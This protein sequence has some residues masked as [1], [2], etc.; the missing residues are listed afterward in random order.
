MTLPK[1]YIFV[2]LQADW[3]RGR[4]AGVGPRPTAG[5][6]GWPQVS[7]CRR[8][9]DYG[10]AL[11]RRGRRRAAASDGSCNTSR[12]PAD[13]N[14]FQTFKPSDTRIYTRLQEIKAH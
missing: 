5:R 14:I 6:P 2:I 9:T 1:L 13:S 8:I 11:V 7:A 4:N 12:L 3:R 10:P